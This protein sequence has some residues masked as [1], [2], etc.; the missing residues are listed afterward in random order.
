MIIF[1]GDFRQVLSVVTKGSRADIVASSISGASFWCYCNVQHL[2][3]S[4]RLM[5]S[6]LSP[7]EH[8]RLWI[9]A[10]WTLNV[11]NGSNQGY[12]FSGGNDSDWVDILEEFFIKNASNGLKNFIE[13]VYPYLVNR[14]KDD[15]YF[16]HCY[17]LAP[18]NTDV[19]ELNNRILIVLPSNSHMYL[20]F[21]THSYQVIR[22]P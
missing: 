10:E 18:L 12:S 9:L 16:Q 2:R 21:D 20:S 19:D 7:T 1:G 22:V 14:Y 5:H 13:F 4:M 17:I 3:I 8:E 11:G 15:S 6:N